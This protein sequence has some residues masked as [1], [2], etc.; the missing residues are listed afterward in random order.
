MTLVKVNNPIS[1]SF[2]GLWNELFEFPAVCS[3]SINE[4]IFNYPAVNIT[5]KNESYEIEMEVPGMKKNDFIIKL[6]GNILTIST[7]KNEEIKNETDKVIRKEFSTKKFKR[8]FTLDEKTDGTNINAK[9]ENGILKLEI[10][11]KEEVKKDVKEIS[12]Q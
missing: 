11:K 1:K 6:D 4:N 7:E 12:I 5:E 9:Y 8:S 3:K 10:P 2:N